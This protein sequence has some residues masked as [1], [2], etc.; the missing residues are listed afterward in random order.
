MRGLVVGK[1]YPLHRGHLALIDEAS[2]H[3]DSLWIVVSDG[4]ADS[5]PAA[6]RADWIRDTYP[7]ASVVVT[8]YD[9]PDES[10]AWAIRCRELLGFPPDVVFT[11]EGYGDEF[12]ALLGARH[13]TI[14]PSRSAFPISGTHLRNDLATNFRYLAPVA[15]AALAKRVC[16]VGVES[17]GTTTLARQLAEHYETVWVP[18]FGRWYW[19][20]R[21]FGIDSDQ[22]DTEEFVTI[23][24]NQVAFEEA[25]AR[26]ANRLVV[27]DTD[28]LATHVWHRRYLGSYSDH[29]W[30]VAAG[31]TYDLYLL[32][33]PDFQFVQDGTREGEAIR[34]EMHEWFREV[35]TEAKRPFVEVSGNEPARLS[36]AIA[37]VDPLLTFQR[38]AESQSTVRDF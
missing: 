23:A 28:A 1:F 19:E 25:L 30:R 27:A 33:S 38:M 29:V 34:H 20:G 10:E 37:A 14:D 36:T 15:A 5:V 24:R 12:A 13:I 2:R 31:Q 21:R 32:T 22:W 16:V 7:Q 8:P 35:L 11:S 18:E 26:R 9:I 6:V 3:C 17:S 4:A